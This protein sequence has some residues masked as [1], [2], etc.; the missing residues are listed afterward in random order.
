LRLIYRRRKINRNLS[1]AL[2]RCAKLLSLRTEIPLNPDGN[3]DFSAVEDGELSDELN[4]LQSDCE[5]MFYAQNAHKDKLYS[6]YSRGKIPWTVYLKCRK[7]VMQNAAIYTKIFVL[8][9]E[10]FAF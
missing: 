3:Y 8:A 4:R 2:R 7:Y 5:R 9:K 1:Y 10:L 6:K